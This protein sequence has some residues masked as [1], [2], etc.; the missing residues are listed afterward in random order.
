ML[1][2]SIDCHIVIG[3]TGFALPF[4]GCRSSRRGTGSS[5]G[6]GGIMRRNSK[7][8]EVS[9]TS[10]GDAVLPL[11][12][13]HPKVPPPSSSSLHYWLVLGTC[14]RRTTVH[15]QPV[16][17]NILA[18]PNVC[19]PP[20]PFAATKSPT[21]Q[22]SIGLASHMIP[23]RKNDKVSGLVALDPSTPVPPEAF[24]YSPVEGL[25]VLILCGTYPRILGRWMSRSDGVGLVSPWN[26]L[27]GSGGGGGRSNLKQI[28]Q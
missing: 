26:A 2:F 11:P 4:G 3:R 8:L 10:L 1:A 7:R 17:L 24:V 13:N 27:Q 18:P 15:D 19:P 25:N 14:L 9:P 5:S 6:G 22:N 12:F 21:A 28:C 20:P 23:C 16:A